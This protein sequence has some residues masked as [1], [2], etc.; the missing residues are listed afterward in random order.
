MQLHPGGSYMHTLKGT[1]QDMFS[2]MSAATVL[3]T[4]HPMEA[5]H[6]ASSSVGNLGADFGVSMS[7]PPG[8]VPCGKRFWP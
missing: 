7:F 5:D 4:T 1:A 8:G 3:R 2:F 6:V